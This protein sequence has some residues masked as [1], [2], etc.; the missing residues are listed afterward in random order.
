MWV[1]DKSTDDIYHLTDRNYCLNLLLFTFCKLSE[2]NYVMGLE[3]EI[4]ENDHLRKYI[5]KYLG[6][7]SIEVSR[8]IIGEII[9]NPGIIINY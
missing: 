8:I 9:E 6:E 2:W 5:L 1:T 4:F 7:L 3:H